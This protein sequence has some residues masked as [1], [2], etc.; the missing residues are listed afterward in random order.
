MIVSYSPCQRGKESAHS[1]HLVLAR[2]KGELYPCA[3]A[4]KR[5]SEECRLFNALEKM[6]E[7]SKPLLYIPHL[8]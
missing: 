8:L 1:E 6:E 5:I 4:P 3:G 7:P 2:T